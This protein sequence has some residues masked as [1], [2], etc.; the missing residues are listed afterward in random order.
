M[1][2]RIPLHPWIAEKE[3]GQLNIKN[4]VL[5]EGEKAAEIPKLSASPTR[6]LQLG[7]PLDFAMVS[8]HAEFLGEVRVCAIKDLYPDAYNSRGCKAL[9]RNLPE[10][11]QLFLTVY[12]GGGKLG[13]FHHSK[14]PLKRFKY[15]GKKGRIVLKLRKPFG[16]K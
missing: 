10:I 3:S 15:C 13:M 6:S 7:R 2:E 5:S 9:R 4:M 16:R 14:K 11:A 1:G 8:D 12:M